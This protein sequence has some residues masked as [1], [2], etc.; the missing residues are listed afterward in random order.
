LPAGL[1]VLVF[2]ACF[3][4]SEVDFGWKCPGFNRLPQVG[5]V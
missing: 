4:A 5:E 2:I 3:A 1:N